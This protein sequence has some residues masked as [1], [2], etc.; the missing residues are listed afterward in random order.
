MITVYGRANSMN[1]QSV[2]WGLAELD[3]PCER[4]D[5]GMGFGGTDTPEYRAMNPNGLVPVLKDENVTMFESGAI[6]RYLAARYARFPFWPED[7]VARA[8]VDMWAEWA[9]TT[10]HRQFLPIF[11]ASI[12]PAPYGEAAQEAALAAFGGPLDILEARLGE[13]DFATGPDFTL[14]DI[15]VGVFL[16]RYF[17][18]DIPRAGRPALEAYYAR[19]CARPT[20]AEHVVVSYDALRAPPA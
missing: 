19:L 17:T 7:P 13:A 12:R 3:Q 1:V 8:P 15:M 14:A 20:Y 2:M 10:L 4:L 18:L 6:L 16:F 5:Y 9:K 11:W